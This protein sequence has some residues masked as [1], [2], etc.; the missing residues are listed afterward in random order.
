MS[1]ARRLRGLLAQGKL[2]QMPC[3]YD[4]LSA[5]LVEQAG[6]P[7]TF[8]SGFGAAAAKGLPDTGLMSFGEVT[9]H[10]R[11]PFSLIHMPA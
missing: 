8:V 11:A 6:F 10:A 5:R 9:G 4:A 2:L 3:C 7:L 1:S